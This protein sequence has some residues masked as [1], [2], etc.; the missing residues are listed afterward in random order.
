MENILIDPITKEVIKGNE[1]IS[2]NLFV[3]N[4]KSLLDWF[5]FSNAGI[6]GLDRTIKVTTSKG[7]RRTA[8]ALIG[9]GYAQAMLRGAL[10]DDEEMEYLLTKYDKKNYRHDCPSFRSNLF[11]LRLTRH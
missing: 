2:F 6:Q 4:Y 9:L 3:F 1:K 5:L 11:L 10:V 8:L 7:G